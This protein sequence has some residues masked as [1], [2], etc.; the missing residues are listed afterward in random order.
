MVAYLGL[1]IDELRGVDSCFR[2]AER[3]GPV[4][5]DNSHDF[6]VIPRLRGYISNIT[7]MIS[8]R[9]CICLEM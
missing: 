8:G 9:F 1:A 3:P 2:V 4:D 6:S 7:G 5:C